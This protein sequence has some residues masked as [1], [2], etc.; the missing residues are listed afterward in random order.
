MDQKTGILTCADVAQW[1]EWLAANHDEAAGVWLKIAKKGAA[2]RTISNG[3]ALDGALCFGWIDS[4]R[5]GLDTD[6]YLQRYS[7]R[8]PKSPW[9]QINVGK[10]EALI[11]AGRMRA[12]GFAAI[13]AARSDGRWQTAYAPQR[14][15]ACPD[16]LTAALNEN[17]LAR[18][19]FGRLDRTARYALMLRLMKAR[20]SAERS[21]RLRRIVA[22]LGG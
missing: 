19:T 4:H 8:R 16:D 12:P 3:E 11:A 13:D 5:R 14:A 10:A 18:I 20:T 21:T 22:E 7:P 15:A 6:H 1:E 2:G 9:S 17:S